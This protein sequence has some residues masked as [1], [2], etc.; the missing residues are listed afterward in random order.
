[1][2]YLINDKCAYIGEFAG[3]IAVLVLLLLALIIFIIVVIF[4]CR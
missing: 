4:M 3:I 1:M 2:L